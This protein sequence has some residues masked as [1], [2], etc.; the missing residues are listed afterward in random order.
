MPD[1]PLRFRCSSCGDV[2]DAR[3]DL[4]RCDCGAPFDLVPVPLDPDAEL[5]GSGVWRYLPWLPVAS[6]VSLGEPMTPLVRLGGGV[7]LKLE[8][9]LPTGSFKDRGA[10]VLVAWLLS[11]GADRVIEDSS[12]NAGAALAAYCARAGIGVDMYV[13]A[14]A[15]AA[16]LGQIR[17]F[18]ARLVPVEGPRP[19]AT[20]AAEDAAAAGAVY[21]SHAW[22]PLFTAGTQTFAWELWEQGGRS[23]PDVVV[24]PVG[25]GGLLL[26]AHLGFAALR[27][28]GL[29]DRVPRLVCAQ[30]EACAPIVRAWEAG[31]DEPA[32]VTATP[33][34][35]D[36]IQI[37]NP[38]RGR[39]ILSAL[40]DSGG[41]AVAVSEDEIREVYDALASRGTLIERTSAVA[42]AAL[43]KPGV[44][45][46]G[47]QVVVAATGNGLKTPA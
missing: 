47:D 18:G 31:A 5:T 3:L 44:M 14:S 12:G 42:V 21:A 45:R 4:L 7:S 29:A 23:V 10:A 8:G 13:P 30:A 32:P 16:K 17:A 2:V 40:R 22:N 24:F 19:A 38:V 28:A 27:D 15:P 46:G 33:S 6:A 1:P 41:T 34:L 11:M 39:S 20:A 35:A 25:H 37:P 36:G 43:A 9:A 26:G